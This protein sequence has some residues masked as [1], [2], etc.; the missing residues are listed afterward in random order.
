MSNQIAVLKP[1]K[2]AVKLPEG[3]EK[4][5]DK[6]IGIRRKISCMDFFYPDRAYLFIWLFIYFDPTKEELH[7]I[8]LIFGNN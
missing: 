3:E 4:K 1:T 7:A 6:V 5:T 2:I 8:D